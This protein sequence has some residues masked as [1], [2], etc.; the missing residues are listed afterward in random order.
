MWRPLWGCLRGTGAQCGG[1]E[2]GAGGP[3]KPP[4]CHVP[5]PPEAPEPPLPSLPAG[6]QPSA[7]KRVNLDHLCFHQP[8][9]LPV[10]QRALGV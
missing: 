1:N 4:P 3:Q 5:H 2:D 6:H 9:G 7:V 8:S 10:N